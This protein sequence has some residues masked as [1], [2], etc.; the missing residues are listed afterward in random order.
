MRTFLEEAD[1]WQESFNKA[2]LDIK[3]ESRWRPSIM[4]YDF[5]NGS[6]VVFRS[7]DDPSKYKS[8]N[9]DGV[10]IDEPVD[11]AEE[12]FL[13]LQG[14]MRG[15]HTNHRFMIMAGNPAG[16]GNWVYQKFFEDPSS[17]YKVIQTTTYDNTYLPQDYVTGMENSFDVDYAN[18]YLMGEWGE[19]EGLIYK[20]FNVER[21]VGNFRDGKYEYYLGGLDYGYRNPTCLLVMGVDAD[22]HLYVIDELYEKEKDSNYLTEEITEMN[23]VF[24]MKKLYCDPSAQN[25]IEMLKQRHIRV[26]EGNN[27]IDE[28]VSKLKSYFKNGIISVD[29]GCK[30]L[31]KELQS[32]RY[33]KDRITKNK[34]ERPI[35]KFDHACDALRYGV[36]KFNPFRKPVLPIGGR[37]R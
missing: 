36:T 11:I 17:E 6:R 21:D 5:W 35:K 9:L 4:T 32:Y 15:M 37:F 30:N 1:L 10:A 33:E 34:T 7:C 2:G 18:R 25:I 29:F 26:L 13:M 27:D 24:P 22:Q 16:Y 8:L 19:F 28:G 20:D 12:V 14:R 31:I 23:R 3:M